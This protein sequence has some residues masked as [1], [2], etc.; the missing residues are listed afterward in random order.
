MTVRQVAEYL[1]VSE[2]SVYR[3]VQ[4]G[5]LPGFKVSGS[6]RFRPDD[7]QRWIDEQKIL[8]ACPD[9]A[10]WPQKKAVASR[11]VSR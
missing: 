1:S 11:A 2:K 5:D 4:A 10:T 8:A 3:L 7:L 6:W 9:R